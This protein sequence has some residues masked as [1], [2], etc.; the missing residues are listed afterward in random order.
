MENTGLPNVKLIKKDAIVTIRIG[1][2]YIERLQEIMGYFSKNITEEQIEKYESELKDVTPYYY[3]NSDKLDPNE[4][5][6]SEDWMGPVTTLSFLF[7]EIE[8][9]ADLQG[10]T[11]EANLEDYVKSKVNEAVVTA[12]SIEE[13]NQSTPQSQ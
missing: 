12:Q 8:R 5:R 13:D 9:Q 10:M 7:K 2:V 1:T 6:F 11:F 3:K 4:K